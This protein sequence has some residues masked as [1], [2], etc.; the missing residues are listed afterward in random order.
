MA[1]SDHVSYCPR[2]SKQNQCC[3]DLIEQRYQ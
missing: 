2:Y 3:I 1:M